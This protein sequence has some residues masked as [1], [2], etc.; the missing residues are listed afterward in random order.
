MVIETEIIKDYLIKHVLLLFK[1][2]M[3]K[4]NKSYN[5]K[6]ILRLNVRL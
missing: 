2:E 6:E 4:E 5:S 3:R 1:D